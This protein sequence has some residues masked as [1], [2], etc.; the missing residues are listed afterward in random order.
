MRQEHK[1]AFDRHQ[2][3]LARLWAMD[4]ATFR[5]VCSMARAV[6][7]EL[8]GKDAWR[9]PSLLPR[10]FGDSVIGDDVALCCG[11]DVPDP[12]DEC[13]NR[14]LWVLMAEPEAKERERARHKLAAWGHNPDKPRNALEVWHYI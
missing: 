5:E 1:D 11:R 10:R 2:Q 7:R 3:R 9:V 13:R 14:R 4:K 8:H 12:L 6:R